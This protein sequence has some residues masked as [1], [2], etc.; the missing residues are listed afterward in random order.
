MRLCCATAVQPER[1]HHK[2][3]LP[4]IS[5]LK[6]QLQQEWHPDNN[7]L[8][9]GVKVKPH[10]GRKFLWSCRN[11]PAGCPH[12][13]LATVKDRTAGTKC[14]YCQG[15]VLC[16]HNALATK[17][18]KQARYWDHNK[19]AKAFEQTLAGSNVRADWKC[20]DCRL[21]WQAQIAMR[22]MKDAGC[23]RCSYSS[24]SKQ[25]M[26]QEEQHALL[27]EWD[28]ERNAELSIFPH[29]TTLQ[30]NKLVHWVC[31]NCPAGRLHRY[32]MRAADRTLRRPRG[33]PYC[34][35]KK[36]CDCNSLAACE[37]T[38]AAE[39][40]FARNEGT[41]ADVTSQSHQVVWWANASRGSW[42]QRIQERTRSRSSTEV[43][44]FVFP[45]FNHHN[46]VSTTAVVFIGQNHLLAG[47]K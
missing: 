28:H 6:P 1:Q 14:P 32:R 16:T 30:S 37:P 47:P 21:E 40:D 46:L 34:A 4:D 35:G 13:W 42:K 18:P 33:C 31:H 38:I 39:W 29:N 15:R 17:A 12:I 44:H 10:S 7:A 19:N 23:P 11:C 24:N 2:L 3:G 8:L 41:P 9:G 43:S 22:V 5:E 20:P 45:D 26:F 36:V 25:P 27:H